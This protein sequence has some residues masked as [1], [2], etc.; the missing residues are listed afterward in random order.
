VQAVDYILTLSAAAMA[1]MRALIF[2][3]RPESLEVE[4]LIA[5]LT[6]QVEATAARHGITIDAHLGPEPDVEI[7][8]KEVLFRV[9]QEALHNVV[10]HS[11]AT[12]AGVSLSNE[13]GLLTLEVTDNGVGFDTTQTFPGHMGL[14]SMPERAA[15]IGAT[16]EITSAPG[17]GTR[18]RVGVP[19]A[20]RVDG[21]SAEQTPV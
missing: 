20:S 18:V 14:I 17:A 19:L 6:K 3:L 4:G 9:C 15:A 12:A 10:K 13:S 5:A 21:G 8:V 7:T 2:E 1:E 11:H 16:C